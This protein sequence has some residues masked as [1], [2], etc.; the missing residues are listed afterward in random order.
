MTTQ[1]MWQAICADGKIHSFYA[2]DGKAALEFAAVME[3]WWGETYRIESRDDS[4]RIFHHLIT[5]GWAENILNG[6]R[7]RIIASNFDGSPA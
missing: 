2:S 3:Q 5:G 7:V 4:G 1:I 6:Q